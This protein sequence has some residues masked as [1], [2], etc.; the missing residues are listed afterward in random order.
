MHTQDGHGNLKGTRHDI[1]R[2]EARGV[3]RAKVEPSSPRPSPRPEVDP[4]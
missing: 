3:G 2:R 4:S 1:M